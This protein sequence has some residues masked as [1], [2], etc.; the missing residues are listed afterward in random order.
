MGW[1]GDWDGMGLTPGSEGTLTAIVEAAR[2]KM[3]K[4]ESCIVKRFLA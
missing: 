2:V 3:R 4:L 1:V